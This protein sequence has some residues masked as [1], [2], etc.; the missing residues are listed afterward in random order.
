L[1]HASA[2]PVTGQP[3]IVLNSVDSTN[4][5]A[6]ALI[7]AESLPDRQEQATH[8]MA[9][10]AL[11]QTEG[12]GQRGKT[13]LTEPGSNIIL[14]LI[15]K[16]ETLTIQEQFFLSIAT[17][18]GVRRFFAG[19][20]GE[21][22]TLIKWPNDLYWRDRKA[23]G[24][25]IESVIGG[26]SFSTGTMPANWKW[27]IAGIGININQTVFPENI[28]NPVSLKQIT[29]KTF[30][31][32]VL[33]KELCGILDIYYRRMEARDWGFLLSEYNQFLYKLNQTVR[34]KKGNRVFEGLVKGVT[35]D[36]RLQVMHALEE[37]F[38][39]GE[40]EWIIASGTGQ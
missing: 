15:L 23:G 35:P 32:L 7:Q 25:L 26:G 19:Y 11:E 38:G 6:M 1:S 3:F 2:S 34:L 12:R 10:F 22:D 37:S 16:P 8:G 24:I 5:Y 27:A 40:V 39:F 4:K 14:S 20:A 29:G 9:V 30:D 36:G 28:P 21:E 18:L 17:A 33:A 13:W 31:S